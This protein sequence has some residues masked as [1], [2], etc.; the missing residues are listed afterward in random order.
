MLKV[1]AP[2]HGYLPAFALIL[3]GCIG[4]AIDRA[5]HGYVSDF[6]YFTGYPAWLISTFNVADLAILTGCVWFAGRYF[7]TAIRRR[8]TNQEA[9]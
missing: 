8:R 3:G 9:T 6:I 4:N 2:E 1:E 7:F 5:W